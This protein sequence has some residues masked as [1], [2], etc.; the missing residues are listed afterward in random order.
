[1]NCGGVPRIQPN[2]SVTV[3]RAPGVT[4]R[5][6]HFLGGNTIVVVVDS[7]Y[8]YRKRV[9]ITT[10]T[11]STNSK[12]LVSAF[13]WPRSNQGTL[14][15]RWWWQYYRR[16]RALFMLSIE[17]I[18]RRARDIYNLQNTPGHLGARSFVWQGGKVSLWGWI[19][20]IPEATKSDLF[21]G[22]KAFSSSLRSLP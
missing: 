10:T 2:I 1:M 7:D 21:P 15:A 5:I 9:A 8:I 22:E 6:L 12:T 14:M 3:Q 20:S 17:V 4:T 16:I 18:S 13:A 11:A 19:S